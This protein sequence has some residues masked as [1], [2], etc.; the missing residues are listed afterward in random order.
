MTMTRKIENVTD[1]MTFGKEI[2]P[3]GTPWALYTAKN[4][5]VNVTGYVSPPSDHLLGL[6]N[7][8]G[9]AKASRV[10]RRRVGAVG[11]G[12]AAWSSSIISATTVRPFTPCSSG[13]PARR[14][15]G[16]AAGKP[17]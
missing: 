2:C 12:H 7:P 14:H 17:W 3:G 6:H 10:H 4:F 1:G 11:H 8:T 9:G 15:V 13:S 5:L 16:Q